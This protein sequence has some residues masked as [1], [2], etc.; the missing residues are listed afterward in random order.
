MEQRLRQGPSFRDGRDKRR[1][2]FLD[3][4]VFVKKKRTPNR[5]RG[6]KLQKLFLEVLFVLFLGSSRGG[7]RVADTVL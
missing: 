1:G 7:A 3:Q 2:L 5:W 4:R 6:R